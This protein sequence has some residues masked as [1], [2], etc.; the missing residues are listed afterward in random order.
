MSKVMT[1]LK[2]ERWFLSPH[3]L[4]LQSGEDRILLYQSLMRRG[5]VAGYEALTVLE[6][7]LR[8]GKVAD[9]VRFADVSTFSLS[10]CLLDNPSGIRIGDEVD[11]KEVPAAV[12]IEK[13]CEDSL[14]VRDLSY[15]ERLGKRRN[16]FDRGHTGNFHQQIG[17][18]LFQ[19]RK[20]DPE[21]WWIYQKFEKSLKKPKNNPYLWVQFEFM[22]Q[23]FNQDLSGQEW[24]DFGCGVGFYSR[25]FA[26]RH[27]RVL[28]VD[29]SDSYVRIAENHFA[30]PGKV[31]FLQAGFENAGD[32]KTF[33]GLRFDAIFLSDVLLY[34][35][36]PYKTMDIT[37]VQLLTEL[38]HLLKP[39]GAIYIMDPHGCFHLQPWLG[40]NAPFLL[41]AEYKNRKYRVTPSLEELSRA[42]EDAN[43]R[44]AKIREL[45]C[46]ESVGPETQARNVTGEFPLWWFFELRKP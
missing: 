2:M 28:G 23:F 37:P 34:Y 33:D 18:Y 1:G 13:L 12:F 42:I 29:P 44:I 24:L 4:I 6:G 30:E 46:P 8:N 7:W 26:D 11:M 21:E 32:F 9:T 22:K 41:C 45:T 43:L 35:F 16:L 17:H 10:E 15:V 14:L 25:F 19:A 5:C 3:T 31:R 40:T 20:G 38:G 27:A 39:G 36:E